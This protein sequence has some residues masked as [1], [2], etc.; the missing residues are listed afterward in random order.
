MLVPTSD[1]H[2]HTQ[3]QPGQRLFST[4]YRWKDWALFEDTKGVSGR[5]RIRIQG[6][7]SFC[8]CWIYTSSHSILESGI[9]EP[10]FLLLSC[11]SFQSCLHNLW[12]VKETTVRFYQIFSY[13]GLSSLYL[14]TMNLYTHYGFSFSFL[15]PSPPAECKGGVG[16]ALPEWTRLSPCCGFCCPDPQEHWTKNKLQNGYYIK[17]F[18]DI[19]NCEL[20]ATGAPM[21]A[22][23]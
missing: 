15:V 17:V 21:W 11:C 22:A 13:P 6:S 1:T 23:R 20:D 18:L 16:G 12:A 2:N 19:P 14:P 5:C 4:F 10:N 7:W 9:T 3:K 8:Q